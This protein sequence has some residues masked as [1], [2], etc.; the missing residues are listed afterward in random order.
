MV[1]SIHSIGRPGAALQAHEAYIHVIILFPWIKT[2]REIAEQLV[3]SRGYPLGDRARQSPDDGI[4][5][6]GLTDQIFFP[7]RRG[8]DQITF[9]F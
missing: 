1:I 5:I 6:C 9:S 3:P 8:I 2:A 7:I 4:G